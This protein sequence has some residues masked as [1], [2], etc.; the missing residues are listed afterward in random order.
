[1][2]RSD[3]LKVLG[4][5]AGG[6]IIPD[7]SFIQTRSVKIYD[8]YVRGLTH[9]RFNQIKQYLKKGDAIQLKRESDN[10][11]DSFAIEIFHN[12]H[13]LGYIAAYEN[14]VLANMMNAGVK[15]SA[16]VS[17][18]HP[19]R[20]I[21]EALAVEIHTDLIIPTPKFIESMLAENRADDANDIYR[22]GNT[23]GI[24]E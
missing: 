21:L 8:N 7:N 13:K 11:Y 14:I 24:E 1:M 10:P 15:L 4:L 6:L 9:Y 3:F 12:E 5:G 22:K 17:Q 16:F 2:K 18:I 19:K 20:N 23:F